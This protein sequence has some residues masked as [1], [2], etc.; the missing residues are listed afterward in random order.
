MQ[1]NLDPPLRRALALAAAAGACLVAALG[2]TTSQASAAYSAR[3]QGG[4]LVLTGDGASDSLVLTPAPPN[5]LFVTLNGATTNSFDTSTFSALEVQAGGGDDEVRMLNGDLGLQS[6]T[7]NGGN[8][9]DRLI[10]GSNAET[11]IGGSGDDF[12]DGN[13]GADSAQ[14]GSG[15][16]TFQWDPGD[17]SDTVEGQSGTDTMQFNGSNIGEHIDVSANGPRVRLTRDVAQINMDFDGIEALNVRALGGTDTVTTDDLTGT[18]LKTASVDLTGFDGAGDSA[19]DSVVANG[20]AAADNVKVSSTADTVTVAGLTPQLQVTGSEPALDN[21]DVDTLGGDDTVTS[22]V[23]LAGPFPV[24]V[25]GGE[26][27]DTATY[28]GTNGDDTIGIARNGTALVAAFTP[29]SGPL[30]VTAVESLNVRGLAGNDTLNATNGIGALTQLTLDGAGGNDT[31]RGGDG[32]DT[33]LAGDGNDLVDGNIGA[34]SAQLGSGN[35][36]FQ[37]DPGDGSDTVEGQGGTDTMQFNASNASDHIDLSA[38]GPRVRLTRDIGQVTMDFAG[39]ERANVATL[40]SSDAVT[41]NDLT[42]TELNNVGVN[43]DGFDGTGDSAADTVTAV[44]TAAADDVD[45]SSTADTVTV[46]GLTPQV[47]VTGSEPTLDNVVVATLGGDDN[48]SSGV[49]HAGPASV[50]FDGGEGADTATYDGTSGDDTIGIARNGTALVAAFTPTSGL[51]NVTA[52]ENLDVRGLAG[53]DTLNATNGIG[54]LT[55]LTLDGAAGNDTLRG[56]D[57]NDA[58]LAGAGDD[59]VDGNIGADNALLGSGNDTFQWDPGDG[60]DTVEGQG[61]TDTMQFNGSN[62]GESIDVSANGPRVRLTRNVALVAMDF[63]GIERLGVRA[64]GGADTI[65]VNDL[66]GTDLKAAT[67][68]LT[69]FDGNGDST[70]DAVVA[71]GSA[72]ADKVAV[73]RSGSQVLTTGLAAQTTIV[74][75]EPANDTLRVNTLGG[76]DTVTVAPDVTDL[77]T[78]VVDLGA[79]Q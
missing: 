48:A 9:D 54:A 24:T 46:A 53:N 38:N 40:G 12:V 67:V 25:D 56:G 79:D 69:G 15:N 3:I 41:V 18:A 32:N 57:G 30:N 64:L 71:N 47:Q 78:P 66:T 59:L 73:T 33:L 13:I 39:I 16:D 60:S 52:V 58:L 7:F 29:T 72:R 70:A 37:W 1:P 19:A 62:I 75:S 17:G 26:G 50:T 14:L 61:G 36:T 6:I 5:T 31:L 65:T 74:G 2:I 68:D 4:T 28:S 76:R 45:V 42:G 23:Q 34:D 35:D 63:D 77:I 44:G 51:F 43:L 8:G 22:G 10:G 49:Q 11:F 27:A 55:Q 20:T 21:V